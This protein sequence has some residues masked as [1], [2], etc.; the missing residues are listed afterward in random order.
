MDRM[1]RVDRAGIPRCGSNGDGNVFPNLENLKVVE[2]FWLLARRLA[3][4]YTGIE[5]EIRE[6]T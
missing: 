5:M 1:A 3:Y 2:S 6:A 4:D